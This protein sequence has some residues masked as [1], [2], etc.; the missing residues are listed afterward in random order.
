[1]KVHSPVSLVQNLKIAGGRLEG[2]KSSSFLVLTRSEE[3][4]PN[5]HG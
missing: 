4:D 2:L 1:M 3:S 5:P